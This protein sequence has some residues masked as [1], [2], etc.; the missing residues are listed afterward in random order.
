MRLALMLQERRFKSSWMKILQ[1]KE[2][3]K[4]KREQCCWTF[5][6]LEM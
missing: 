1:S 2:E 5:L 4:K 6:Q 3:K